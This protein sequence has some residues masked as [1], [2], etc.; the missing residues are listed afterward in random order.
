MLTAKQEARSLLEKF[1][2]NCSIEDIQYHLYVLEK[3]R[4]GLEDARQNGAISEVSSISPDHPERDEA[5]PPKVPDIYFFPTSTMR[6]T[7]TGLKKPIG[8]ELRI[9]AEIGQVDEFLTKS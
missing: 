9:E 3:V 8:N 2:D 5:R 1:P 4:S 7:R 6:G